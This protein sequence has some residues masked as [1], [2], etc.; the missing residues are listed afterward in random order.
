MSWTEEMFTE[1]ESSLDET[2]AILGSSLAQLGSLFTYGKARITKGRLKWLP[3][4]RAPVD[5][6]TKADR[7]E[8]T[9]NR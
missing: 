4:S 1:T 9:G 2:Y 8:L 5:Y 7:R 6:K 3:R